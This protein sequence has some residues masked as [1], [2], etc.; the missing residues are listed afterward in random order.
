GRRVRDPA[1]RDSRLR[2]RGGPM[3]DRRSVFRKAGSELEAEVV[4][5]RPEIDP[6]RKGRNNQKKLS[7]REAKRIREKYQTGQFTQ[8]QLA[9]M[10]DVNDATVSRI[11]RGIYYGG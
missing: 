4:E 9:D 11:V 6:L 10:F 5:L 8:A 2:R 3:G 7:P 1:G